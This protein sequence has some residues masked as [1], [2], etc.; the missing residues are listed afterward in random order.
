[1]SKQTIS[2]DVDVPEEGYELVGWSRPKKG[3]PLIDVTGQSVI[4]ADRDY[5]EPRLILRRI[6]PKR[7]SRWRNLYLIGSM[8]GDMWHESRKDADCRAMRNREAVERVDYENGR[9]VSVALEQEESH[10]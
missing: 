10:G 6:E 4:I 1:M 9:P 3:E 7:E 2:I 5:D 8:A